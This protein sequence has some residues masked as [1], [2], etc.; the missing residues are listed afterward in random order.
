[1]KKTLTTLTL[2]LALTVFAFP[3]SHQ[4]SA[5]HTATS[6][7]HHTTSTTHHDHNYYANSSGQRVHTPVHSN[8]A[9]A[10]AT[11]KC[12]DGTYSFS[13]HHGGTCSHHGGVSSWLTH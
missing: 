10:G 5:H 7:T 9:L 3:S 2:A 6:G 13:A 1:M 4:S 11:A 12:G 8:S